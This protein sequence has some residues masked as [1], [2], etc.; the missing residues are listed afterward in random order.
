MG[1]ELGLGLSNIVAI[2]R[3]SLL[4]GSNISKLC[5][6]L[7]LFAYFIIFLDS[8]HSVLEMHALSPTMVSLYEQLYLFVVLFSFLLVLYRML[9]NFLL[10]FQTQG[11]VAK[12]LKKEGD[13][14]S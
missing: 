1:I 14:V 3:H 2:E 5:S 12:W 9:V 11:N 8:S 13:K 7:T 6:D 10:W 4:I